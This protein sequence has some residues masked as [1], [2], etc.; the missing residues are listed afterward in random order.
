MARFPEREYFTAAN[1][2]LFVKFRCFREEDGQKSER[3]ENCPTVVFNWFGETV[4]V[5]KTKRS[6]HYVYSWLSG[7][8]ERVT[9][10]HDELAAHMRGLFG[11][12]YRGLKGRGENGMRI[13]IRREEVQA[14]ASHFRMTPF[15]TGKNVNPNLDP[16]PNPARLLSV[17]EKFCTKVLKALEAH[18][19]TQGLTLERFV[20]EFL[21][22]G[23]SK[24]GVNQ[25]RGFELPGIGVVAVSCLTRTD[26]GRN[27]FQ[28]LLSWSKRTRNRNK[29]NY[30][31]AK[32]NGTKEYYDDLAGKQE[33]FLICCDP[34][35]F[36]PV[37][38]HIIHYNKVT[39]VEYSGKAETAC[40]GSTSPGWL[41]CPKAW[42]G[43]GSIDLPHI[44]NLGT[45]TPWNDEE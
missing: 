23:K 29:E 18:L 26:P 15:I 45:V 11:H 20:G 9:G 38:R 42:L 39:P 13:P 27:E 40:H 37:P 7:T 1:G 21:N 30:R 24:E 35:K 5:E 34:G 32:E 28:Q 4:K 16:T 3:Q 6:R 31:M 41:L 17:Q 14:L 19:K 36:G 33:L 43:P 25:H 10:I 22:N 12:L 44:E 8:G 2:V